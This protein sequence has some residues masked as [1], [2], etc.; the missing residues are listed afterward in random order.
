VFCGDHAGLHRLQI[1]A[2]GQAAI[3]KI[4]RN[5]ATHHQA[6]LLP[7]RPVGPV[8]NPPLMRIH[9][10]CWTCSHS[11][12]SLSQ[13]L[14]EAA[15]LHDCDLHESPPWWARLERTPPQLPIKLKL[16]QRGVQPGFRVQ[17]SPTCEL[18]GRPVMLDMPRSARRPSTAGPLR[19]PPCAAGPRT[20][21]PGR[22]GRRPTSGPSSC[23]RPPT[24]LHLSAAPGQALSLS[25]ARLGRLADPAG[26]GCARRAFREMARRR[27]GCRHFPPGAPGPA[28]P[29]RPDHLAQPG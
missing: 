7:L 26:R 10:T 3:R 19:P 14:V 9:F 5:R 27:L 1:R 25:A 4:R 2:E 12:V 23:A 13:G 29:T 11:G 6:S 8:P 15:T 17:L 21:S 24:K 20:G 16:T 18:N 28:Q 22:R